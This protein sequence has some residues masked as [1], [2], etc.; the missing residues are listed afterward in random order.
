MTSG[1][2]GKNRLELDN[3]STDEEDIQALKQLEQHFEINDITDAWLSAPVF[4][5]VCRSIGFKKPAELGYPGLLED[6]N[7]LY[8]EKSHEIVARYRLYNTKLGEGQS[9]EEWLSELHEAAKGA[10]SL[11][12]V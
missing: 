7:W 8:D 12:Q 5:N 11:R 10:I 4:D 1:D 2:E 9:Y 6:L 3:R